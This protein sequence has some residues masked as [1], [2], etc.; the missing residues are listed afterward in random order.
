MNEIKLMTQDNYII[1][2]NKFYLMAYSEYFN[3]MFTHDIIEKNEKLIKLE[4]NYEEINTLLEF[5]VPPYNLFKEIN[6][7]NCKIIYELA[8]KYMVEMLTDKCKEFYLKTP[9]LWTIQTLKMAEKLDI[10]ELEE[11]CIETICKHP[12]KINRTTFKNEK[13]WKKAFFLIRELYTQNLEQFLKIKCSYCSKNICPNN[14]YYERTCNMVCCQ[15]RP[16]N[17]KPCDCDR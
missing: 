12:S 16:L 7:E 10:P 1:S 14:I 2:C 6:I 4:E 3:K 17:S 9:S 15:H 13:S 5:I 8:D 11:K